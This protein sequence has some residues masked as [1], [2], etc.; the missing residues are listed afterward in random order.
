MPNLGASFS[1]CPTNHQ[2]LLASSVAHF[3][4]TRKGLSKQR[5]GEYLGNL[6]NSFN[7][8]VLDYFIQ[9]IDLRNLMIDDALRKVCVWFKL[10]VCLPFIGLDSSKEKTFTLSDSHILM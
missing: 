7:Q 6:Q 1:L 10:F 8:R 9:E 4:I 3:M 2:D 5:I